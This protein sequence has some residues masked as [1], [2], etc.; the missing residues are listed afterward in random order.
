M[1]QS[2]RILNINI[3]FNPKTGMQNLK[4]FLLIFFFLILL[5]LDGT[6]TFKIENNSK[7][8]LKES[9]N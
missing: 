1:A 5:Y 9:F 8:H 4:L 2:E 3:E 7:T 6:F